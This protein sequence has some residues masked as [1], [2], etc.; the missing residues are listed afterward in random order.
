MLTAFSLCPVLHSN[1]TDRR[2]SSA[3]RRGVGWAEAKKPVCVLDLVLRMRQKRMSTGELTQ[4]L[5]RVQ[6]LGL[7]CIEPI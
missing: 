4:G 1:P 3:V 5:K 6:S 2:Q 7:K